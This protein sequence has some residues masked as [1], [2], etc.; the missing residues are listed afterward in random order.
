MRIG[1]VSTV[2]T[3]VPPP[4][5]GS[6]ELLVSL[7][8]GELARRGH[9]VTLFATGDSA[10]TS[11]RVV[12]LLPRGYLHDPS[13]WDWQLAEF[14]QLG[15]VFEQAAE[16]DVIH[17]HVYC[18]AL[19]FARLTS[20]P[21][22]QTFHIGP[23]PDF[24]RYCRLYPECANVLV[25]EF[26]RTFFAD[27]PV[28]GVVC[29]GIDTKAFPFRPEPGEYLAF[30]AEW[31]PDKGATEAIR[32][33]RA[34]RIPL[35]LA[36][37][38]NDYFETVV[39]PEVDGEAVAY[40]GEVDHSGKVDLLGRALGTLFFPAPREACPLAVLES[41]ACGTPV[42]SLRQGPVPELVTEGHGILVDSLENMIEHASRLKS[43]D[44][45]A[46]RREA[47][48]R[49]DV[50]RMVDDYLAVYERAIV[51]RRR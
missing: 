27:A 38:R 35:R 11:Y 20:T 49:F 25:S 40:V 17:S 44:R 1:L 2:R 10:A 48:T 39:R 30:I 7:L 36:G 31:R 8:A 19:P 23:T 9:Q 42:L 45:T 15:R 3:A 33:A 32:V 13:I 46:I 50:A 24:V 5:A 41:M 51:A 22:V 28:A 47:V 12:S 14:V 26:Q 21:I 16:F 18:Y 37:P 6:V 4:K 29:N 34:A 43:L